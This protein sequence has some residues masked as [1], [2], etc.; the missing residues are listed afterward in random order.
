M[1]DW[2]RVWECQY[3]VNILLL[4][5]KLL[6]EVAETERFSWTHLLDLIPEEDCEAT[7]G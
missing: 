7:H 6:K 2:T 1:H 4:L 3:K 5:I